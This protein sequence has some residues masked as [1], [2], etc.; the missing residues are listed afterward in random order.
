MADPRLKAILICRGLGIAASIA[1]FL[2]SC[3]GGGASMGQTRQLIAL[4]VQPSNGDAIAPTGTLP[5]SA[6]GTFNEA[7]TSQANMTVQW[8][9][10]NSS[11]ATI[12]PNTGLATCVAIGGPVTIT[13]SA[14]GNGGIVDASATLNCLGSPPGPGHIGSCLVDSGKT[15]TGYCVGARGGICHEAYDPTNCPVGQ[16]PTGVTSDQCGSSGSFNVDASRSCTP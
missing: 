3:G 9:S 14:P 12:D 15:L 1:A 11:V 7:P 13:A 8:V 16:P 4:A 10:S 5:F 6:T 2:A